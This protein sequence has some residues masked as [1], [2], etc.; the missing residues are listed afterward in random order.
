MCVLIIGETCVTF[1]M[2]LT[3]AI[4]GLIL[5]GLGFLAVVQYNKSLQENEAP[6]GYVRT[7]PSYPEE[8]VVEEYEHPYPVGARVLAGTSDLG[9]EAYLVV[10]SYDEEESEVFCELHVEVPAGATNV[11]I[12]HEY[13]DDT[14]LGSVSVHYQLGARAIEDKIS[15]SNEALEDGSYRVIIN[16]SQSWDT[17]L[18]AR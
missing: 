1:G 17:D 14:Q 3:A 2:F 4:V 11:F 8:E 16:V 15:L 6:T 12:D 10:M 5:L 7:E 9:Q 18:T 13:D